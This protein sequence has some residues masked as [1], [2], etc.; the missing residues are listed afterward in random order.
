MGSGESE[1]VGC[2][3]GN[4]ACGWPP[5]LSLACVFSF[6]CFS[7]RALPCVEFGFSWHRVGAIDGEVTVAVG[8]RWTS[9][10]SGL[11]INDPLPRRVPPWC[12]N[13]GR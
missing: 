10:L 8:D 2:A 13:R 3:Q 6:L 12:M 5:R 11:V 9:H 4:I 7:C 1:A